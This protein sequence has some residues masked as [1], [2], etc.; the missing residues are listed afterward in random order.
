MAP[1]FPNDE[2]RSATV[3]RNARQRAGLS[4]REAALRAGT[5]HATLS[6]YETGR[7]TP[8]VDNFLRILE[9]LGYAVNFE[10]HPRIRQADGLDRGE[11]LAQ[12]LQLAEQFP[13][14]VSRHMTYPRFPKTP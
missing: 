14:K 5:S 4:L 2:L 3:L 11:E 1:H 12:V 13:V 8:S 6:A 10:L 7:K 9:S